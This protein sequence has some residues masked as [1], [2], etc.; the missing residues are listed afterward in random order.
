MAG[1]LSLSPRIPPAR[2]RGSTLLRHALLLAIMLLLQYP[3]GSAEREVDTEHLE[4]A[5][6]YLRVAL[7]IGN[8]RFQHYPQLANPAHD[9]EDIAAQLRR[10]GFEVIEREDLTSREIGATLREFRFK[11]AGAEVGLV[12]FAG[13]GMQINGENFFPGVDAD[14]SSEEDVP[15]QSLALRQVMDVLDGAKTQLNLVFLDACR[16]N[17]FA[18][19]TR[20]GSRGLARVEAPSGTLISYATRPGS[21]AHDGTGRNGLYTTQLLH[22]I[23]DSADLPIEVVLKRVV[24]G[25]KQESSG[26]QEPW[27][28]GSLEGDFC[29]G[30]CV[31]STR[32]ALEATPQ[33]GDPASPPAAPAIVPPVAKPRSRP[34]RHVAAAAAPAT[35]AA[36]AANIAAS[37]PTPVAPP[38]VSRTVAVSVAQLEPLYFTRAFSRTESGSIFRLDGTQIMLAH[39]RTTPGNGGLYSVAESPSGDIFFCDAT[40]SRIL[41]IAGG[42]ETI[43]YQHNRPVK[44]LAFNAAG[45]LFFSSVMGSQDPGTIYEL[46]AGKPVLFYTLPANAIGG[47]WSGTFAFDR[48]GMLWLSSGSRRPGSLYRA[49][50]NQLEK[51]FTSNDTAIMGFTFLNDGSI[52]FADNAHSVMHLTLP[53]LGLSR[54]FESPYDDGALTDV[55]L[56]SAIDRGA[57]HVAH[58][59]DSKPQ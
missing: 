34:V 26:Q 15:N 54:L 2:P 1:C 43:E 51:V 45:R 28:E 55:K 33:A 21:V 22:Q 36:P 20:S 12:F 31:T 59:P 37:I 9:A 56:A 50:F 44:H 46:R 17:P 53:A 16:D 29:F 4:G 10:L 30:T 38:P 42:Q 35:A 18:R 32:L 39:T 13:H 23:R 3:A 48:Q 19:A 49:R 41:K 5:Q 8:S 24:V 14:I 6:H 11:L 25:V 58:L 52:A 57:E 40:E 27:Y 47:M 7:V